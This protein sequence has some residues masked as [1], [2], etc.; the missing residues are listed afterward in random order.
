LLQAQPVALTT[1]IVFEAF[2]GGNARMD[3][4]HSGGRNHHPG[5]RGA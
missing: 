2:Q 3:A 1:L 5:S 4:D